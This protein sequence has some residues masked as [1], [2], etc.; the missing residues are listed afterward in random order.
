MKLK[1]GA[2]QKQSALYQGVCTHEQRWLKEGEKKGKRTG[3]RVGNNRSS[4]FSSFIPLPPPST[5]LN[6]LFFFSYYL[7]ASFSVIFFHFLSRQIGK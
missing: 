3:G 4:L 1:R 6:F 2:E 7:I 5:P